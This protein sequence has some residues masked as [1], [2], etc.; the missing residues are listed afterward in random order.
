M[1]LSLKERLRQVTGVW[2]GTYT[3]V[4]PKG[5]VLDTF[6]SRQETRLEGN[7]WYERV[8]Y[9]WPEGDAIQFDFH[10]RFDAMGETMIFDDP[11]FH[12]EVI[13]VNDQVYVFPY[14]WKA[15]PQSHVVETIVMVTPHYK[16]RVWQTFEQG[17]LIKVTIINEH[18]A[19]AVPEI[20][21]PP[22]YITT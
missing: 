22:K 10:A 16:S 3:H 8:T 18:R 11:N 15:K 14:H 20:W 6:T 9:Q 19:S 13:F 12:G 17:E 5:E 21:Y 2:A 7:D 4:T 1:V